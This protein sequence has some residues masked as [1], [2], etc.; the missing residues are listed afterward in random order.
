MLFLHSFKSVNGL[1]SSNKLSLILR[2][3]LCDELGI[4]GSVCIVIC[5]GVDL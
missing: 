4:F 2:L 1:N 3:M 5:L